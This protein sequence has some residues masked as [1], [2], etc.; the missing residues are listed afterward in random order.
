M[1]F[2][3]KSLAGP[4]IAALVFGTVSCSGSG[5]SAGVTAVPSPAPTA[6]G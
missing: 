6:S 5:G 1:T 3:V 4:I 2:N